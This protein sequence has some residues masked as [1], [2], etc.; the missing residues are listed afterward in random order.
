MSGP[1]E[2][3]V[4]MK[5]QAAVNRFLYQ[6]P[7]KYEAATNDVHLC[8]VF[9]KVDSGSGKTVHIERILF[10]EFIKTIEV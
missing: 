5:V 3:V 7:Q 6:T 10:P 1:Y 4:G 8:G 2:S 9:L